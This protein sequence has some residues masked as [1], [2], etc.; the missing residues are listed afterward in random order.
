MGVGGTGAEEEARCGACRRHAT[1]AIASSVKRWVWIAIC[2]GL[3][4]AALWA[5][6]HVPSDGSESTLPPS[7]EID[8]ASRRALEHVL[9]EAERNEAPA[10]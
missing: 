2:A 4:A 9:E 7:A 10:P 5:A 8:D 6:R 1:D 3:A